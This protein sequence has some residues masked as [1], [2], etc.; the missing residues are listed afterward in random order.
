MSITRLKFHLGKEFRMDVVISRTSRCGVCRFPRPQ[1]GCWGPQSPQ[2]SVGLPVHFR[3]I[4]SYFRKTLGIFIGIGHSTANEL[5][6]G[7]GVQF[8][9]SSAYYRH[10]KDIVKLVEQ[11]SKESMAEAAAK[12]RAHA[13]EIGSVDETT[14]KAKIA[15]ACDASWL[16][17]SYGHGYTSLLGSVSNYCI[18]SNL[19]Y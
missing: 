15:V 18:L 5:L 4:R 17:A 9:S 7:M 19:F 14:G 10:L 11:L 8:T 13:F 6:A 1:M 16:K 2:S 12:E 3:A